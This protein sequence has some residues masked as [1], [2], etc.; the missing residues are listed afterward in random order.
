MDDRSPTAPLESAPAAG[1]PDARRGAGDLAQA[2]EPLQEEPLRVALFDT[3]IDPFEVALLESGHLVLFRKVWR[4][5]ARSI[6]GALVA[7][8]PFLEQ[9]VGDPFRAS[10][11][12][13]V[14]D[15]QVRWQGRPLATVG[16]TGADPYLARAPEVDGAMLQ[17]MRLSPPLGAME[18]AVHAERLPAG[19]G[20]GVLAW[21]SVALAAVLV[22][23]FG[24]LYRLGLRQIALVRQQQDFVSAVSHEL[25]T[26]LTSIRMYAEMLREGWVDDARR[27]DYYDTIG[28]E[29]ER[30]SR[31][32]Q[33]VLQLARMSRRELR[34]QPRVLG[35]AEVVEDLRRA[36][37]AQVEAAGFTLR[38]DCPPEAA[39]AAI[40]A[41]PDALTQIGVNLVDNALKFAARAER[42]EIVLSCGLLR[43]GE[44]A[45]G[46]RDYGPGIPKGQAK[47]V[48]EL[49]Y[50]ADGGLTRDTPG[51][52]LG[53]GIVRELAAAMGGR[54][55]L[56]HHRP[57]VEVRAV[58]REKGDGGIIL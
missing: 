18:L 13:R 20:A 38:V 41:D 15:L 24:L 33:N 48:F 56:V 1:A 45:L 44:L 21:L 55:E 42:R 3:E 54:T 16:G 9:V 52:G 58:F 28:R 8:R 37:V 17:R 31:L 40:E 32:V 2:P 14:A 22:G 12:A 53:L 34:L 5:G 35:A 25:R 23:G 19:P 43:G 47:R 27:R 57:G 39:V 29:A 51:T 36:V 6:Q 46:V 7:Q 49:F 10:A 50:R 4:G 26:P 11:V 30:L